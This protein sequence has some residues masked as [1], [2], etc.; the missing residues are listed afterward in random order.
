MLKRISMQIGNGKEQRNVVKC[1]TG[2]REIA[3]VCR[4]IVCRPQVST[5]VSTLSVN[6]VARRPHFN[7]VTL[8]IPLLY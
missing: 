6:M 8:V 2:A 1:K 5:M 4:L 7:V 3:I